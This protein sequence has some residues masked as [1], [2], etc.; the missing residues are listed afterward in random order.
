MS[1]INE[2]FVSIMSSEI[3]LLHPV[4]D[5]LGSL[6]ATSVDFITT[7]MIIFISENTLTLSLTRPLTKNFRNKLPS[8][9]RRRIK[10]LMAG[11]RG[12]S[13]RN[14]S[15]PRS[16]M[17]G[18]IHFRKNTNTSLTSIFNNL[19]HIFLSILLIFRI[20]TLPEIRESNGLRRLSLTISNMPMKN[21]KLSISKR[22]N[23]LLDGSNR[24]KVTRGIHKNTTVSKTR[25][26][27]D[28]PRALSN[29]EVLISIIIS[30]HLRKSFKSMISTKDSLRSNLNGRSSISNG[31]SVRFISF[32]RKRNRRIFNMNIKKRKSRLGILVSMIEGL[33]ME[34]SEGISNIFNLR[35]STKLELRIN[36]KRNLTIGV[37]LR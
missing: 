10:R 8:S 19:S 23:E 27:T 20:S 33:S 28:L 7:K 36:G 11:S 17:S 32:K 26:I 25:S 37:F 35:T 16:F 9:L 21:I 13:I 34:T 4:N 12:T 5:S 29:D 1:S 15:T 31:K 18:N 14:T 24:L 22:I 3:V 6:P 2:I 30:D